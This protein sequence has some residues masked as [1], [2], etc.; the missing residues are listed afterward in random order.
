MKLGKGVNKLSELLLVLI[1]I[2]III[3]HFYGVIQI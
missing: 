3:L 1:I 2:I